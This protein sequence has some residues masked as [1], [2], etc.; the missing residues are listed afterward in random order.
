ML[1]HLDSIVFPDRCEVIEV[2]PSQRYVYCIFKNGRSSLMQ[3]AEL[4][5]QRILINDQIKKL[6]SIDMVLRDP[7]ERLESGINTY[8]QTVMRDH[9]DLDRATVIWFAKN[10]LF[11]NRHYAPQLHWLVNL[12]RYMNPETKLNF[13]GMDQLHTLTELNRKPQGIQD[14]SDE[15]RGQLTNIAHTEMYHRCD[16][17]LM[18]H[19]GQSMT[20]AQVMADVKQTDPTAYDCVIGR[21]QRI[22][23]PTYAV[24]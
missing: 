16:Q 24:S 21:S 4:Y 11:L 14:I 1:S 18:S 9:P 19:I 13:M 6:T 3:Q 2:I 8:I 23:N 20:F 7:Q 15:L 17:V 22:L 10:Y 5:Q 12:A